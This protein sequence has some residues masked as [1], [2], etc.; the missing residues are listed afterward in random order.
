MST[1][2]SV[3]FDVGDT[4]TFNYYGG[5]SYGSKRKVQVTEVTLKTLSGIDLDEGSG[6]YKKFMKDKIGNFKVVKANLDESVKEVEKIL[7]KYPSQ[8][9]T[10]VPLFNKEHGVNYVWSNKKLIPRPKSV[11]G[12]ITIEKDKITIKVNGTTYQIDNNGCCT[13]NNTYYGY[14]SIASFLGLLANEI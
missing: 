2:G 7:K 13:R 14:Y 5:S 12:T 4:V 1:L 10:L 8:A 9:S 3:T 6:A 11:D